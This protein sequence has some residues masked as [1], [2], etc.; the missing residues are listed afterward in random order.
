MAELQPSRPA[1]GNGLRRVVVTGLGMVT[2]LGC[3]V[4]PTWSRLV[5]GESGAIWVDDV[6]DVSRSTRQ[7]RMLHSPRRCGERRVAVEADQCP[8]SWRL[9]PCQRVFGE[10]VDRRRRAKALREIVT[11]VVALDEHPVM[12][13]AAIAGKALADIGLVHHAEY[14]RALVQQR[15]QRAPD[16][17]PL[18]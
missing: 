8:L 13:G 18:R 9:R 17:K 7:G 4:E 6:I 2:P 16:R 10:M 5:A 3:G 15:D 11:P 1:T 14:R 12:G